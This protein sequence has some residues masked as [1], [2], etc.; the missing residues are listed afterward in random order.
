[1]RF[2][3][4]RNQ[5]VYGG[6]MQTGRKRLT[7]CQRIKRQVA[8]CVFGQASAMSHLKS[9]DTAIKSEG[10]GGR[11]LTLGPGERARPRGKT[12]GEAPGTRLSDDHARER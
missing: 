7:F 3:F 8:D 5:K 12:P 10:G 4:C 9:T 2:A 6:K 11:T 1:M